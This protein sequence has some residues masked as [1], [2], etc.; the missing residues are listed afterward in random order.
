MVIY[1]AQMIGSAV[2]SGGRRVMSCPQL[3]LH[4]LTCTTVAVDEDIDSF[5]NT[6]A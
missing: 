1:T 2:Q 3:S 4:L 5:D 6:D